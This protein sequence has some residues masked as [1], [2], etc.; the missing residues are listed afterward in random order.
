MVIYLNIFKNFS[1]LL[2]ITNIMVN[3]KIIS[4][5]I[6]MLHSNNFIQSKSNT[7]GFRGDGPTNKRAIVWTG[8][9][10]S[11]QFKSETQNGSNQFCIWN[12]WYFK[13]STDINLSF[14][15]AN[16]DEYIN[17]ECLNFWGNDSKNNNSHDIKNILTIKNVNLS[18]Q[19]FYNIQYNYKSGGNF[20]IQNH[21]FSSYPFQLI[22]VP[23][24]INF[25]LK[26][27]KS[28]L[29]YG[30]RISLW[31]DSNYNLQNYIDSNIISITYNWEV[32][33]QD[34]WKSL[35]NNTNEIRDIFLE[36]GNYK[37]KVNIKISICE[38]NN[39]Y[40]P[41]DLNITS[42][43]IEL[44]VNNKLGLSEPIYK[45]KEEKLYIDFNVI[46]N[47]HIIDNLNFINYGWYIF[48]IDLQEWELYNNQ[49]TLI[50]NLTKSN[51]YMFKCSTTDDFE[52][53]LSEE[54][55]IL[56]QYKSMD[57]NVK[58][59]N[60]FDKNYEYKLMD[61]QFNII[62]SG[63]LL[64]NEF[65]PEY[66][67]NMN[68]KLYLWVKDEDNNQYWKLI[69]IEIFSNNDNNDNS[70]SSTPPTNEETSETIN[71]KKP[72]Y[73]QSWFLILI[74]ICGFGLILLIIWVFIHLMK[75]KN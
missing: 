30:E 42:N 45:L 67:H 10:V 34:K 8:D 44:I 35:V 3:T 43:T 24:D 36:P 28:N 9:S 18:N 63:K 56:E 46:Y 37:F 47:S 11:F 65:I 31:I 57:G 21:I 58:F 53:I 15:N 25:E 50:I 51:K 40:K 27:T 61:S 1:L 20:G 13:N 32:L 60:N 55:I 17:W 14:N 64:K 71:N 6:A 29:V 5:E 22:V 59:T 12:E 16:Y 49:K 62:N 38:E 19:G 52:T 69:N 23:K 72:F 7:V 41:I 26:S 2:I 39:I 68:E 75:K 73:K 54:I 48:N 4:P 66:K 70:E 74:T 33:Y